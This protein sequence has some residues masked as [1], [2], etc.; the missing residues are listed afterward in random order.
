V[1]L[2]YTRALDEALA[3]FDG[4]ED[5]RLHCSL[6]TTHRDTHSVLIMLGSA[7]RVDEEGRDLYWRMQFC[8]AHG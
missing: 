8:I 7:Q 4:G 1:R 5:A 6:G 2:D 3:R